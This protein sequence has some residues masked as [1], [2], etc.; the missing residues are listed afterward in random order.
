MPIFEYQCKECSDKYEIL[1]KSLSSNEK[2]ECPSCGSLKNSKLF[3]AFSSTV[4]SSSSFGGCADGSCGMP[5]PPAGG[6]SSGMC[7]LN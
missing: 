3:S 6:C 2:I 1:H 5:A 7:G 4:S